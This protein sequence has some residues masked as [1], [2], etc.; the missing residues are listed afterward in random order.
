VPRVRVVHACARACT[1]VSVCVR[2]CVCACV[3]ACACVQICV[4]ARVHVAQLG[5]PE[6]Q[7]LLF[8]GLFWGRWGFFKASGVFWGRLGCAKAS[9][10]RGASF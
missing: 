3:C 8:W 4:R 5:S 6:Y 9:H 1:C 10:G 7:D 2:V